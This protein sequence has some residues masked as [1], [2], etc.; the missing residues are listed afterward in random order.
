MNYYLFLD[1]SGDHGIKNIY[2]NFPVFVLCGIIISQSGYES[3][4]MS[5]NKIKH[6][7]WGDN[8]VVMDQF[9]SRVCTK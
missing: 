7:F 3:L 5:F 1:E 2:F 6:N 9:K 4:N 8:K